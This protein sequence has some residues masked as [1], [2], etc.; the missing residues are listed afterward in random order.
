MILLLLKYLHG[1]D[2]SIKT[3]ICNKNMNTNYFSTIIFCQF[4]KCFG[5][6]L[7][8]CLTYLDYSIISPLH[9][10]N[11]S[12]SEMSNNSNGYYEHYITELYKNVFFIIN[13]MSAS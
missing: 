10:L 13:S 5:T 6:V 1:A 12:E 3:D 9:L 8:K 4:F 2:I 11:L 7:I